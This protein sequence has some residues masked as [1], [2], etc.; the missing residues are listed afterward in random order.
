[1]FIA[2]VI[3]HHF[4]QDQDSKLL[5]LSNSTHLRPEQPFKESVTLTNTVMLQVNSSNSER[6]MLISG[7]KKNL[8]YIFFSGFLFNR[9]AK[10]FPSTIG[11]CF[12]KVR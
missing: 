10:V 4:Q 5:K 2:Q 8:I 3:L 7:G 6:L 11:S 12:S 1:M 9:T